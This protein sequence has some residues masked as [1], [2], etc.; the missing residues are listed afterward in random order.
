MRVS[1]RTFELVQVNWDLAACRDMD[2]D[3]FFPVTETGPLCKAQIEQAKGVCNRCPIME[4]CRA[5]AIATAQADGV[6]GG[7]SAV[8]RRRW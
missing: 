7:L 2:T 8:E 6:W 4:R 3:L 5:W 1:C